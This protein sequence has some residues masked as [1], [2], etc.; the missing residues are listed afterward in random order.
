MATPGDSP[1]AITQAENNFARLAPKFRLGEN[2]WDVFVNLYK[3][4]SLRYA[5]SDYQ[6]KNIMFCSLQGEALALA[7][8]DYNPDQEPYKSMK[9]SEYAE[10]LQE[11]FEPAAESEQMRI[12]FEHRYQI[13]GEHPE[14]YFRD[15]Q[16][17]FFRAY[18]PE[19]RDYEFFYDKVI[20]GL[21][22]QRMKDSLRE[23]RPNPITDS[24]SFRQKM[25]FLAT[26]Q[27]RRLINGE[28]TE[29]EALGAEAHASHVSY[30]YH[31]ATSNYQSSPFQLKSEPVNAINALNQGKARPKGACFHCGSTD[32]F[33][34][35]CPRKISGLSPAVASMEDAE[36]ESD[37]DRVQYVQRPTYYSRGNGHGKGR[38]VQPSP[39]TGSG[40]GQQI[41]FPAK[42]FGNKARGAK[43]F[44]RRIA[45]IYENE[46]GET[47]HD[48]IQEIPDSST[49]QVQE[50]ASEKPESQDPTSSGLNSIGN[51][52]NQYAYTEADYMP[53]TFLGM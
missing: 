50:G 2:T 18:K 10:A 15:K 41:R 3:V 43:R 34:A 13:Q 52:E 19:L 53:S 47:V 7:T 46:Q 39:Q 22:N 49:D 16:R 35:Q 23:Y 33:V 38:Y 36:A 5:C 30:R 6:F 27:R 12:E 25:I 28:C 45:Y 24:N 51:I 17:M 32:H 44:N 40:S 1:P 20:T 29:A 8:P 4:T 42:K 21:I 48:W 14:M 9:G 37:D 26:V 31:T 11:L